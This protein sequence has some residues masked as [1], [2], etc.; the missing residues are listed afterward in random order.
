MKHSSP[1]TRAGDVTADDAREA[2]GAAPDFDDVFYVPG[3]TKRG[4]RRPRGR[5]RRLRGETPPQATSNATPPVRAAVPLFSRPNRR[6][7]D[8]D[9]SKGLRA[10]LGRLPEVPVAAR[11]T[12]TKW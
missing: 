8:D 6:L 7:P 2:L 5:H 12:G 10:A 9:G 11:T 3:I 1:A 4:S